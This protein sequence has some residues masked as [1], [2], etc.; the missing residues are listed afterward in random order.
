M[1]KVVLSPSIAGR[2]FGLRHS[3]RNLEYV[4]LFILYGII[5]LLALATDQFIGHVGFKRRL[6]HLSLAFWLHISSIV[7]LFLHHKYSVSYGI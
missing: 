1:R 6:T 4:S 3:H 2:G 7:S 5:T